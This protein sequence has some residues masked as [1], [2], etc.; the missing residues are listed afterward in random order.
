MTSLRVATT[1]RH[2]S[3]TTPSKVK[4]TRSRARNSPDISQSMCERNFSPYKAADCT[5]SANNTGAV[6]DVC[7]D[8]RIQSLFLNSSV[9]ARLP[10]TVRSEV[11]GFV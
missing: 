4:G 10:A 11:T 9:N 3:S 2:H 6:Q 7:V 5:V 1:P 8:G